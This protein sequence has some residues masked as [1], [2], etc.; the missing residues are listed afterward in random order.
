MSEQ[1]RRHVGPH[2]PPTA[3]GIVRHEV[4]AGD[5]VETGDVVARV[6]PPD[7]APDEE[8]ELTID[9]D[10]WITH[11][12]PGVSAYENSPVASLAIKDDNDVVGTPEEDD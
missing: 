2:A 3:A 7:D 8:I 11:R 6:V 9:H 1:V 10:G 4:A 12:Y 5:V